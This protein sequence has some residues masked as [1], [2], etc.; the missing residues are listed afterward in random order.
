MT[1]LSWLWTWAIKVAIWFFIL[2]SDTMTTDCGFVDAWKVILLRL[3]KWVSKLSLL[4]LFEK[5]KEKWLGKIFIS[6]FPRKNSQLNREKKGTILLNLLFMSII[7]P[8]IFNH[9][10]GVS[11]SSDSQWASLSFICLISSSDFIIWFDGRVCTLRWNL[12]LSFCRW[13]WMEIRPV[14]ASIPDD[15]EV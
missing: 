12:S 15:R 10:L 1:R 4:F 2:A 6:L 3:H 9:C 5:W 8:L 11:L 14:M 13:R 7:R